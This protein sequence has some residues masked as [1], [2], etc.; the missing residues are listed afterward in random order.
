MIT[1]IC[2]VY[3]PVKDSAIESAIKPGSAIVGWPTN[4]DDTQA[5]VYFEGNVYGAENL[6][7][8]LERL[9]VAAYRLRDRAPTVA[10]MKAD[11]AELICVAQFDIEKRVLT[12][13]HPQR[14]S[15]LI[16]WVGKYHS[17]KTERVGC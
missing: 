17:G 1:D 16:E 11:L 12:E 2:Y 9:F 13:A 15:E 6:H 14:Q 10:K 4:P 8:Y 3:V 5:I 7:N